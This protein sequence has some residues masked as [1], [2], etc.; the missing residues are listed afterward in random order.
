MTNQINYR[1]T[2]SRQAQ[3]PALA[4]RE[5]TLLIA[6]SVCSTSALSTLHFLLFS[7]L[8]SRAFDYYP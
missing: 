5:V 4:G 1:H 2:I 7:P 6:N 3:N 8:L